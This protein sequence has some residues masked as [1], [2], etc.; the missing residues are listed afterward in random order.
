MND[1]NSSVASYLNYLDVTILPRMLISYNEKENMYS[2]PV[3]NK[4]Y[5]HVL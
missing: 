4:K 2:M 1:F 3:I 5:G